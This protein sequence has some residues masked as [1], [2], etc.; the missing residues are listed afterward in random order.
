MLGNMSETLFLP[1]IIPHFDKYDMVAGNVLDAPHLYGTSISHVLL[2]L[3]QVSKALQKLIMTSTFHNN[4][5]DDL[6]K[7]M[8]PNGVEAYTFQDSKENN[9]RSVEENDDNQIEANS[10]G[11]EGVYNS[12]WPEDSE[13]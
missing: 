6:I 12:R 13:D 4:K 1:H 11:S 2:E 9:V 8:V 10:E 7:M 5:V 3:M